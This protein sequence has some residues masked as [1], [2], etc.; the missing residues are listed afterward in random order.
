[1]VHTIL[2]A[3]KD[4]R[5]AGREKPGVRWPRSR[6]GHG[7]A[8]TAEATVPRTE[9]IVAVYQRL[10]RLIVE[11]HLGPGARLVEAELATRFGVSR[12]P[13]RTALYQLLQEGFVEA[14]AAGRQSRLSVT[15]VT[16]Q[17]A[18]E[19]F[20]IV[21]EIEGLAARWAAGLPDATRAAL[22][23]ELEELNAAM[24]VAA[25]QSSPHA[26]ETI[27]LDT[28]FHRAYVQ[29]GAGRRLRSFHDSIKPQ[30]DRFIYV[31]HTTLTTEIIVSTGEHAVIIGAIRD[32]DAVGARR[33]VQ[34]NWES[35]AARL[36][37]SI[38]LV[39]ERGVW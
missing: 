30:A 21:G 8:V 31:Y 3:I 25:T 26:V 23:T 2:D 39:G 12:T 24:A 19:I 14:R 32:G 38:A 11:G 34:S 29:A 17:D 4:T 37:A 15:P 7:A 13:I 20:G 10:R 33:A 6:L 16:R 5:V 22:V 18:I 36:C 1:M 28:A 35:A 9:L 27:R